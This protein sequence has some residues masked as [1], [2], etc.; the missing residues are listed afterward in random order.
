[1][2]AINERKVV[3]KRKRIGPSLREKS[4]FHVGLFSEYFIVSTSLDVGLRTYL[5]VPGS[6][7]IV[8]FN[9]GRSSRIM[10]LFL[11]ADS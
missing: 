8:S 6:A 2:T 11:I 1:M 3:G 4:R 5:P 9:Q 10:T 7:S